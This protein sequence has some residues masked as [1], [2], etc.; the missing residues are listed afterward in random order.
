MKN[1]QNAI[2]KIHPIIMN[3]KGKFLEAKESEKMD[4]KH[5]KPTSR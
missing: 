1:I 5:H 4:K 2:L 3:S